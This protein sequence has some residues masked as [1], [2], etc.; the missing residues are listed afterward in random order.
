MWRTVLSIVAGLVAWAVVATILNFGV[1]LWL[2]GYAQAEPVMAFTLVMK[3]ARLSLAAL[4]CLAAG[5]LVRAIAPASRAAPWIVG[6]ILLC[7]FVPVHIQLWTKFPIWYH[8]TFLL[9]LAPLVALGAALW[10]ARQRP[11]TAS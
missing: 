5:A 10:P 3:I 7:L 1:R 6:L 9:T 4:A 8:L 11:V 2:P